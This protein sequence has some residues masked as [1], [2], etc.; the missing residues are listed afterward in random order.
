MGQW[1]GA[2]LI[3][4]AEWPIEAQLIGVE[5]TAVERSSAALLSVAQS[6]RPLE[7]QHMDIPVIPAIA[8]PMYLTVQEDTMAVATDTAAPPPAQLLAEPLLQAPIDVEQP[9]IA[10]LPLRVALPCGP[11]AQE[12]L[13]EAA[14]V[15]DKF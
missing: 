12:S 15:E 2:E 11:V 5:L 10:V 3:V 8:I 6:E 9:P 13:L 7:P 1:A 14:V 4:E